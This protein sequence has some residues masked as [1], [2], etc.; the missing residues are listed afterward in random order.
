MNKY[1]RFYETVSVLF[2]MRSPFSMYRR[3]IFV[4]VDARGEGTLETPGV[5]CTNTVAAADKEI[6]AREGN[7]ETTVAVAHD[8]TSRSDET[9]LDS[10]QEDN[11]TTAAI[12]DMFGLDLVHRRQPPTRLRFDLMRP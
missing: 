9:K 4:Q 10:D 1:G 6:I 5:Q 11:Q 12:D 2:H 3:Q 8:V 7:A